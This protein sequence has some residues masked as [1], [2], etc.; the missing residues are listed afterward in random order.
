MPGK[1]MK[2]TREYIRS[3]ECP[4][5]DTVKARAEEVIKLTAE[6]AV[7]RHRL[8]E[9]DMGEYDKIEQMNEV[10]QL[11][12][13]LGRAYTNMSKELVYH[14]SRTTPQITQGN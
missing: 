5:P 2:L 8:A 11:H 12:Y 7:K 10:A 3:A 14:L 13:Q 1:P 9:L 6:L 4:W